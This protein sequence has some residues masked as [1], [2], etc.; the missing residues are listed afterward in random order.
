[1]QQYCSYLLIILLCGF[2]LS[3]FA[4]AT[5]DPQ[6]PSPLYIKMMKNWASTTNFAENASQVAVDKFERDLK[7]DPQL[8]KFA[9]KELL[10]DLKQFFYE[11]FNS[12]ETMLA[13][14]SAYSEYY[15]IDELQALIKFY[16]SPLGK[17]LISTHPA[18]SLR[19]QAVGD[20]MLKS[21]E[22]DYI[23]IVAKYI[24]KNARSTE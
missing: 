5:A 23:D 6:G 16:E 19:T 18:L 22:K 24:G 21:K 3:T 9:T 4:A 13:L 15:S 14:A 12:Q 10:L 1:M 11:L 17:K 2:S 7:K 20:Q 8:A